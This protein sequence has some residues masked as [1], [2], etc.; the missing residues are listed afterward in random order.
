LLVTFPTPAVRDRPAPNEKARLVWRCS[1]EVITLA[2]IVLK[3]LF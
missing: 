1:P 2:D 3:V